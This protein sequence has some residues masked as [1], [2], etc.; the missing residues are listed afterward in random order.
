MPTEQQIVFNASLPNVAFLFSKILQGG[1]V[2]IPHKTK[3]EF[4]NPF[5]RITEVKKRK[6]TTLSTIL[7]N[8]LEMFFQPPVDSDYLLF[9]HNFIGTRICEECDKCKDT[10]STSEINLAIIMRDNNRTPCKSF[11]QVIYN[12]FM[13]AIITCKRCNSKYTSIPNKE[14]YMKPPPMVI[15]F[16][17]SLNEYKGNKKFDIDS[18]LTDGDFVYS[19]FAVAYGSGTHFIARIF[20][21][22]GDIYEYDGND[23]DAMLKKLRGGTRDSHKT[24]IN[25]NYYADKVIYLRNVA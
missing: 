15:I 17:V 9:S 14:F 8:L 6:F 3:M 12:N 11:L 7:D 1:N 22:D 2:P 10:F 5:N 16:D 4:Y 23:N 19:L 24:F 18:K 20:G 21:I 13:T 25:G